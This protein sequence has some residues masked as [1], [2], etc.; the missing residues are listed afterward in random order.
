MNDSDFV[1]VHGLH[2]LQA[3]LPVRAP[4]EYKI[5]LSVFHQR[6]E[7][8]TGEMSLV[9]GYPT[10]SNAK[11]FHDGHQLPAEGIIPHPGDQF[12]FPTQRGNGSGNIGWSAA[13]LLEKMLPL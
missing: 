12:H 4:V 5:P 13:R 6:Y 11:F 7:S 2:F 10:G 8:K 1:Q 9:Q 3:Q